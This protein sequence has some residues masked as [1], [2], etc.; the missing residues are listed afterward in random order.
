MKPSGGKTFSANKIRKTAQGR[1]ELHSKLRQT[2]YMVIL[3][4]SEK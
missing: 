4:Y 3:K 2:I 1:I